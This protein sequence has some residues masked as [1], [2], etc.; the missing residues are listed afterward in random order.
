MYFKRKNNNVRTL[1][2]VTLGVAAITALA[3]CGSSSGGA[4]KS[5]VVKFA[6]INLLT[7]PVA[8]PGQHSDH[9]SHL[10]AKQ[11]NDA[12]GLKDS[13]GNTWKVKITSKDFGNSKEQAIALFREAAGDKSVL[14]VLG[15]APS[16]GFVAIQPVSEQM[17]ISVISGGPAATIDKWSPY[18]YRINITPPQ[19][20]PVLMQELHDKLNIKRVA[21]LYDQANDGNASDAK[22]LKTLAPKIGYKLVAS[23][24]FRTGD[25]DQRAQLTKIAGTKPDLIVLDSIGEDLARSINQAAEAGLGDV[26]KSTMGDQFSDINTWKLT[27]GK[28][29]GG[30]SYTAAGAVSSAADIGTFADQYKTEFKEDSNIFSLYGHDELAVYLDA[31]KRSCTNSDREKFNKALRATK[32][33]KGLATTVSFGGKTGENLTPS[34][35]VI[36]VTAPGVSEP[37]KF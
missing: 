30:Y 3:A 26:P 22:L 19:G 1:A 18:A 34:V 14:G 16:V 15:P 20:T 25:T 10:Y 36:Q 29:K 24:A 6:A 4:A 32:D 31:V 5:N 8:G 37:A 28:V 9:G 12:G 33:V 17:K 27:D 13:C 35:A 21:V 11:I 7:G 2:T 23:E